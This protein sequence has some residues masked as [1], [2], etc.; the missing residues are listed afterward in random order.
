[1]TMLEPRLKLWPPILKGAAA[2]FYLETVHVKHQ[3]KVS[4]I[5]ELNKSKI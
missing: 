3:L 5:S 1:M 4:E 2:L